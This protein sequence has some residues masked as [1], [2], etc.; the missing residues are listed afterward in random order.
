[1]T[2]ESKWVRLGSVR[3]FDRVE[4]S[5][6]QALKPLE[7]AA[8]VFGAWQAWD[9][10]G[11]D[12]VRLAHEIACECADVISAT[13]NLLAALGV[14][15]ARPLLRGCRERNAARGR[16]TDGRGPE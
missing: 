7:E 3:R 9:R 4:P 14:E 1:M 13:V 10:A 2:N 6:A 5:K 15:D 16:I 11:R 8:E 12:D